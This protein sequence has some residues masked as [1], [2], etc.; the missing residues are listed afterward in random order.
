MT[1]TKV[2]WA[3]LALAGLWGSSFLFIRLG[4]DELEP[5]TLV[6]IRTG[7]ALITLAAIL[8]LN[9]HQ[10]PS[11]RR[12]L[13]HLLIVGVM[14]PAVPYAL[15][16]WGQQF[17]DSAIAGIINATV[18]FFTLVF[19]H[20]ALPDEAINGKKLSGL[21][22][23]FLGVL[24]IFSRELVMGPGG[25]ET[26]GGAS[27]GS[28]APMGLLAMVG[29]A[30]CYG[31][32][33]VYVRRHLR[34]TSPEIVAATSQ[35]VAFLLTAISALTLET[36]LSS[37]ISGSGWLVVAWLGISSGVSYLLFYFLLREWGTTRTSLVTYLV[38]VIAVV[39]GAWVLD[40]VIT[41]QAILGG[42][43]VI[44][45]VTITNLEARSRREGQG[46]TVQPAQ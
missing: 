22:V 38:P 15:I 30:I 20:F 46:S 26:I 11:D 12:A 36:P 6:T 14:N 28:G 2:F 9:D 29:A 33:M 45:G 13:L 8:R 1:K 41:W 42:A 19:A 5:F 32:S 37:P 18:P 25:S 40:E 24:L 17:V 4:L 21:L 44:S 39:L 3:F 10:P 7:F 23:G 31:G 34:E 43:F 16:T 27:S 35:G